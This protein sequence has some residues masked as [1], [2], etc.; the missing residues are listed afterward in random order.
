MNI[1]VTGEV[2][3]IVRRNVE[4]GRFSDADSVVREAL[5]QLQE[6]N[7]TPDDEIATVQEKLRR[8]LRQAEHNEFTDQSVA[9]IRAEARA[10]RACV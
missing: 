1:T 2:A 8:G 10:R 7:A 3:E 9:D 4:S 6:R 5:L